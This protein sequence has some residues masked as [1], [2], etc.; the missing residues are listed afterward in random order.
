MLLLSGVSTAES[1]TEESISERFNWQPLQLIPAD[2]RD[3]QCWRCG[4]KYIDPLADVDTSV[5]P[6]ESDLEVVGD[7]DISDT[8]AVFADT[9]VV[10]QATGGSRPNRFESTG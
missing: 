5:S 6:A 10:Q 8:S 3:D 2:E 9:V 1:L 7:S 4:G